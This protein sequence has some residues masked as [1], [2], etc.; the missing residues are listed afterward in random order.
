MHCSSADAFHSDNS[1][2]ALLVLE[3]SAGSFVISSADH[4]NDISAGISPATGTIHLYTRVSV[5]LTADRLACDLRLIDALT[6]CLPA[7][8]EIVTTQILL[9]EPLGSLAFK[10]VQVRQLVEEQQVKLEIS[11]WV[12]LCLSKA[13]VFP[14]L[15]CIVLISRDRPKKISRVRVGAKHLRAHVRAR[16]PV[17]A[18]AR[19]RARAHAGAGAGA[20]ARAR[21]TVAM[22]ALRRTLH[23]THAKVGAAAPEEYPEAARVQNSISSSYWDKSNGSSICE[24]ESSLGLNDDYGDDLANEVLVSEAMRRKYVTVLMSSSLTEVVCLMLEKKQSCA[25]I[26]DDKNQLI[27]QITLSDIQLNIEKTQPAPIAIS[28]ITSSQSHLPK[29]P[30]NKAT[31]QWRFLTWKQSLVS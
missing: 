11:R 13:Y 19:A 3:R 12:A 6:T 8:Y 29:T 15:S 24:L 14:C 5:F 18:R 23:F 9:A 27:G 7:F 26:V 30:T 1:A 21:R 28:K 31:L 10:M 17:R 2:V 16:A 20:G 4:S 25:V 22:G